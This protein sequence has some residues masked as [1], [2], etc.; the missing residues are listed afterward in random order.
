MAKDEGILAKNSLAAER[1]S[2]IVL[3]HSSTNT[4]SHSQIRNRQ[5]KMKS[6]YKKAGC[7]AIVLF[8][9]FIFRPT[10]GLAVPPVPAG[11]RIRPS[12][13]G[14]FL[15]HPP[16]PPNSVWN[17]QLSSQNIDFVVNY[18]PAN[19]C[20]TTGIE[21]FL[22]AGAPVKWP[23]AAKDAFEYAL[24]IWSSLL[25]AGQPITINA[26]WID[27]GA[28]NPLGTG[29]PVSVFE[30][31]TDA[32][33]AGTMYPVALANQLAQ[34]DLNDTDDDDHDQDGSDADAEIIIAIN[35]QTNWYFGTDA[36]PPGGQ[37]D[38]ATTALHE[39]GHG[40]GF[41]SSLFVYSDGGEDVCAA[42]NAV[43]GEGCW[44]MGFGTPLVYDRFV[45][46]NAGQSLIDTDLFTNPST[47]LAAQL[48]GD[49]IFFNGT[50]ANQANGGTRPQLYAPNPF[51]TGSS[52]LHLDQT[53]YSGT[54]N[55]LMIPSAINPQHHP[56]PVVLGIFKDMGWIVITDK[57][58]LP[59]VLAGEN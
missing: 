1:C 45:E 6:I 13:G 12:A 14:G 2:S 8:S 11:I 9:L 5:V 54:E 38:F 21:D 19:G 34:T 3:R 25:I 35:S 46:N 39:I 29:Q 57:T 30:N 42:A 22:P 43:D 18:N 59:I 10:P 52:I 49:A 53:T 27:P 47:Q 17:S 16:P 24:N 41:V 20:T 4:M 58:F 33:L 36:N 28:A 55:Q 44:G 31:F 15:R 37:I 48:T 56:G 51:D 26:C 50:A 40:L 23:D 7:A 32:P